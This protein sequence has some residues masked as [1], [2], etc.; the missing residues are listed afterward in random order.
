MARGEAR[1]VEAQAP[2]GPGI[3]GA[4]TLIALGNVASRVLGLVR[5]TVIADL[6]G[7]TGL[8]SAFDVASRVPRMLFDL[9]ID[10]LVSSALVPVFSELA[11]RDPDE[12][13]RV[14]SIMLSLAVLVMSAAALL[15]E[16]FAH[17]VAWLMS[18]GFEPALLED[19]ARL[20]RITTPAVLFLS[21]SGI[22]TGLLYA[23]K[24]FA[25]PAFT[26]A[27]F[28]ASIV[29][30]ALL[31]A[32]VLGWGVESLALGLLVGSAMQVALQVPGLRGA[33]LRFNLNW[34]HPQLRRIVRLYTPVVL[35]LVVSQIGI[36]I[37]RNLAS[38]T[39]EQSIAWMRYATTLVQFPLG[40][41]SVAVALAILPTLSRQASSPA[42]ADLD[43]FMD[44]LAAGLKMVLALILPAVAGLFVLAGPV[45]AL[46]FEHG[47]F[48]PFDTAQTALALRIYLLGTTFAA[49]DLPLVYAFYARKNT[50]TPALV[51]VLGV[52]FYLAAALAPALFRDLRMTD[53][54]LANSVQLTGH[55]LVML[56]LAHRLGSL[57]RRGLGQTALK[58]LAASLVMGGLV[59]VSAQRLTMYLPGQGLLHKALVVGG[60][61]L[62]GLVVYA[63]AVTWLG[64][65]EVGMFV[66]LVRR[67]LRARDLLPQNP[68]K[69]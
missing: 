19:T 17:Q 9:L 56:W 52:G 7:A 61:A 16:L 6:F 23:L 64:V 3:A 58:T 41:V 11:E 37:D 51:G 45:V 14:A 50:L 38:R 31:L 2:V 8:V 28:N 10:G 57:R 59:F 33:H 20:M 21:L 62:A 68:S 43:E 32:G 54:V 53:L 55:A 39:G 49:I 24:R 44:T 67:R 42:D 12:L 22:T 4:A 25:L 30:V 65:E 63:T 46:V 18:G 48:T 5:E 69:Q 15:L 26:A 29:V 34:H 47:D 35:G 13:W 27:V 66:A 36:V 60:A 1:E 40:L